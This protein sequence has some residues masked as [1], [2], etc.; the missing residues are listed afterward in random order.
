MDVKDLRYFIAVYEAEGF[1][2]AS[3]ELGTVQ[4]NVSA[5]I[6]N[7]EGSLGVPL[8]ERR[9]RR[10][11]PTAGGDKLYR[12]AKKVL[13]SLSDAERALRPQPREGLH[14]ARAAGGGGDHRPARRLR[15]AALLRPGRQVRGQRRQG[16]DRRAGEGARPVPAR[17]RPL[18]RRT[19]LG[20]KA[21]VRAPGER[22]EVERPVPEEGRAARPLGQALPLQGPR[23]RRATSTSSPTAATASPA[24]AAKTPTSPTT[25]PAMRFELRAITQDG[26]L[27]SVRLPGAR[28]AVGARSRPRAAATPCSRCAR[29]AS[30]VARGAAARF[31]V[32]LFSQELLV[33]LD[34]GLPLVEAI[35]TLAQKEQ[36]A[37]V[38]R[39]CSAGVLGAAAPGPAALGRARAGAGRVPAAL[40]RHGARRRAH[41]RPG[42]GAV[43]LRRLPGAARGDPQARASTPSIYPAAA[44][45]RRRAGRACSCCSTWCRASARSTRSAAPTCRCSRS[46]C[47][48]GASSSRRTPCWRSAAG[49]GAGRRRGAM[50]CASASVRAALGDALWRMPGARRAP[51]GLPAR[52][53]LPH[54]RH[55]AEGRHAAGRRARHGGGAAA[56]GAA[57]A[58]GG[59]EPRDQRRAPRVR[60][61]WTPTASPRR[62][63]CACCASASAAAAWAR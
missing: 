58:A 20:L 4:S 50:R 59:G 6:R 62:S 7:L 51:Q 56:P 23:A 24:A 52:A 28:R 36:R 18:S 13:D 14:A 17:H 19:E 16:A 3:R 44:D 63:R 45:R 55:A 22:G 10:V 31:P 15:R 53:L 33:L 43:A 48:P 2:R 49:R 34:A 35:E 37:R 29:G 39:A 46:C 11:A 27:E 9:Y 41:Q 30:L 61:R 38:P 57:R 32:P 21:L 42:A 12:H 60:T 54:H 47:S 1:S 5:R 25:R 40:R 26:R 8:F